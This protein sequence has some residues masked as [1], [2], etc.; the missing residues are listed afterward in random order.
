MYTPVLVQYVEPI[1]LAGEA[2]QKPQ[3]RWLEI[4]APSSRLPG[5]AQCLRSCFRVPIPESGYVQLELLPSDGFS[6]PQHYIVKLF[7]GT[8]TKPDV[9]QNWHIPRWEKYETIDIVR[10]D[11]PY[12]PLPWHV[13]SQIKIPGYEKWFYKDQHIHWVEGAPPPGTAYSLSYVRPLSLYQV[14]M[15]D[16]V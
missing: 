15:V 5:Y 9:V 3:A 2:P 8:N 10:T 11:Q 6:S 1:R 7:T 14:L 13:F 4:T 16:S 12:D